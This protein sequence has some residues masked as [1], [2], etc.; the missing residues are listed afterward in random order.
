[1][2]TAH[3]R[4]DSADR[5]VERPSGAPVGVPSV[6]ACDRTTRPTLDVMLAWLRAWHASAVTDTGMG[7]PPE[8]PQHVFEAVSRLASDM[9]L[10]MG[11]SRSQAA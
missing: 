8:H 10:V 2:A 4:G 9:R 7:I 5:R 3:P 1:M 6:R 11:T